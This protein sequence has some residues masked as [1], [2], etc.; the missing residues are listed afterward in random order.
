MV[1]EVLMVYAY[2]AIMRLESTST[3]KVSGVLLGIIGVVLAVYAQ[4]AS[5]GSTNILWAILAIGVP[6]GYAGI[7]IMAASS[8]NVQTSPQTTLGLASLAGIIIML[9]IAWNQDGYIPCLLYT[10]PSPR[11][12]RQ[13]RMPSSA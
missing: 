7:D 2:S 1:T 9:P 4:R 12:K 10:S 6:L 3:K 5:D 13:A 8:R 11:D